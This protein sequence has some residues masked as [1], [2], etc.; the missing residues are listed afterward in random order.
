MCDDHAPAVG[1][2]A[3]DS[4]WA[5]FLTEGAFRGPALLLA[6]S[7]VVGRGAPA[8]AEEFARIGWVHRVRVIAAAA[9][10][11]EIA[12]LVAEAEAFA[13]G[14]VIVVG[15]EAEWALGRAVAEACRLPLLLHR[16]D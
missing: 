5:S 9:D 6:S 2:A 13:A 1:A 15:D 12:D 16:A 7:A 11:G 4:R 10:D 8:W 14:V 3:R